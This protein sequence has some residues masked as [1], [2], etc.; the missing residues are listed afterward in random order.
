MNFGPDR[1][2]NGIAAGGGGSAVKK[3]S[4][5]GSGLGGLFSVIVP[6]AGFAALLLGLAGVSCLSG[7][8]GLRGL[9]RELLNLYSGGLS[10]FRCAAGTPGG[11][12]LFAGV[13]TVAAVFG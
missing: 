2:L 5:F 9:N 8:S 7:L 12:V 4:G 13:G 10:V 6:A 11:G 1:G 3:R